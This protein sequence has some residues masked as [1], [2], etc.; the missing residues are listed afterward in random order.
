MERLPEL[1]AVENDGSQLFKDLVLPYLNNL[2]QKIG[3]IMNSKKPILGNSIGAF[4]GKFKLKDK[5]YVDWIF[6]PSRDV[7][8]ITLKQFQNIKTLDL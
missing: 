2:K 4:Y 7:K 6:Q 8:I 3:G 5:V 1:W